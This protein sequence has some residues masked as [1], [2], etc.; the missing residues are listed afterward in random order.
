[1]RYELPIRTFTFTIGLGF[2]LFVLLWIQ[3][4][5]LFITI[6]FA[7]NFAIIFTSICFE[8]GGIS[9]VLDWFTQRRQFQQYKSQQ[10]IALERIYKSLFDI[11]DQLQKNFI[12]TGI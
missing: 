7:L 6:A 2:V 10:Q 8:V 11:A 3:A 5:G 9:L 4:L 1:M 12:N